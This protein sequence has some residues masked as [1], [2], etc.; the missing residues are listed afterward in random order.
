MYRLASPPAAKSSHCTTFRTLLTGQSCSLPRKKQLTRRKPSTTGVAER[1]QQANTSVASLHEVKSP[2]LLKVFSDN[3]KRITNY[4]VWD[5]RVKKGAEVT[6]F[7][8][9]WCLNRKELWTERRPNSE[10]IQR[11]KRL[12]HFFIRFGVKKK[13]W[14]DLMKWEVASF[15]WKPQ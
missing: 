5:K 4:D 8:I 15:L 11:E 3:K 7:K 6:E 12:S 1:G 9:Q 14:W 2:E 13:P 10:N